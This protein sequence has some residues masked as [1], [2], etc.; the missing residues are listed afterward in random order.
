MTRIP[1]R[2]NIGTMDNYFPLLM[3]PHEGSLIT[4]MVLKLLS[5]DTFILLNTT[6]DTKNICLYELYLLS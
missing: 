2:D 5:K 3:F 1:Q 4:T 6:E